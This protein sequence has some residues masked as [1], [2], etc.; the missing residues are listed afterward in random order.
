MDLRIGVIA[1][2]CVL[3]VPVAVVIE[4]IRTLVSVAVAVIIDTVLVLE[5]AGVDV[6]VGVV[7]VSLELGVPVAVVIDRVAGLNAE[8]TLSSTDVPLGIFGPKDDDVVA[9]L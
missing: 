9:R 1:V 4:G 8:L 3:R 6:F 5:C 7:A 2:A